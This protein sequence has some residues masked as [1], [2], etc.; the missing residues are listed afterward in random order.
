MQTISTK[1]GLLHGI[2]SY[3]QFPCGGIKACMVNEYNEVETPLGY[4]VP[5]YEDGTA[6]RKYG[7]SI[8]FYSNGNIKSIS[9]HQQTII[10]TSIGRFP[11]ELLTFYENG[12]LKRLFP[13]NGKISGYWTEENEYDLAVEFDFSLALGSFKKKVIAIYLYASGS[14]K[15]LTFWPN[16]SVAIQSPL[17]EVDTRIGITLYPNGLLKSLE[18]NK[19]W[20]VRTP[21]GEIIAYNPQ[22][23]GIHGDTNSFN[24]YPDGSIKSLMTSSNMI[25]VTDQNGKPQ[26]WG[27]S[28]K[29][30][31]LDYNRM[32]VTPLCLEFHEGLV[33]IG[34]TVFYQYEID[35][36]TFLIDSVPTLFLPPCN[37]CSAC[38]A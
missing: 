16:D 38:D 4:L 8:T 30:S 2:S 34:S 18:P 13:L 28:L 26:I 11:A 32:E 27:P 3:E 23:I 6:R 5:Q 33:K 24:F 12:N 36:C 1:C 20:A 25:T 19:P 14:I 37:E 10:P 15:G 22:A 9:L 31:L 21:I 29:P 35:K 7:D 17:G